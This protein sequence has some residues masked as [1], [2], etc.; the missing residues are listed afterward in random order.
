MASPELLQGLIE[1]TLASSAAILLVLSLRR[2]LRRWFGAQA[3]YALWVLVPAAML[4]TLLPAATVDAGH[5]PVVQALL[6][7]VFVAPAASEQEA[8]GWSRFLPGLWLSG[9]AVFAA[10]SWY[11]QVAFRRSLGH[12]RAHGDVLR[13]QVAQ[14]GLPA[15]LGLWRPQVVLPAD[16]ETRFDPAQR[17]LVLAH[18]RAHIARRDAWANA[19]AALLRCLFWF[20]PLFHFAASCMRHDQELACDA[21]VLAA[22]PQQRRSYGDALLNAQLALQVAPLGCHFGFGHPLK[23]RIAMLGTSELSSMRRFSGAAMVAVLG[24]GV[25]FVAWASQPRPVAAPAAP[26]RQVETLQ[27]GRVDAA[28]RT[29]NPPAYPADALQEQKEGMVVL[30]VEIDA[31][32]H[33]VGLKVEHSSGDARLDSAAMAAAAKWKFQPALE[34]GKPVASKVKVPVQFAMHAPAVDGAG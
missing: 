11:A 20:N 21:D 28:S 30:V 22:H 23:E 16:F 12:L 2:R 19:T 1:A 24:C 33:P 5:M 26:A 27:P 6:P 7:P 8:G 10:W 25:A 18:E 34:R 9:T 4:A 3:A 15:T 14:A 17:A 31:A 29:L 32:G 13:A